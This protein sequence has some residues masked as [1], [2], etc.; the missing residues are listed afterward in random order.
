MVRFWLDSGQK[1]V[2]IWSE[3]GRFQVR[4][5]LDLG[6]IMVEKWSDSDVGWTSENDV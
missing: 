1:M 2:V 5:R 3:Y 4:K 6:R